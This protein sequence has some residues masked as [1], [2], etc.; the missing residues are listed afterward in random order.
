MRVIILLG[1][2]ICVLG[3]QGIAQ[4]T[5][6]GF[7][8]GNILDENK[9]AIEQATVRLISKTDSNRVYGAVTDKNGFFSFSAI[10]FDLYQLNIS[11]ISFK[12]LVIDS[13]HFR[14]ERF[15][16]NLQD[17]ILKINN[18][19]SLNE[20]VVYF[21]KPLI[22]SKEGNI[23][24]NAAESALAAGSTAS[25]LLQTVPLI[26]KDPNG[27]ILVRG[28]EPK[29][30]IDDK[31]VELN[32]QQLQDLLESLPGSSI[33]KIEVMTNPAPQYASEQGGVINIVTKK[34]KIGMGGRVSVSM[35]TRGEQSASGNFNYRKNKFA[36]NL[37]SGI[38][39][40]RFEGF[41]NSSRR[42]L[43]NDSSTYFNT[44]SNNHNESERPN[45]RIN[46]DYDLAKNQSLNFVM[47]FN[48][49]NFDNYNFITYTHLNTNYGTFGLSERT[50]NGIG[51][52][53]N[54][55]LNLTYTLRGKK[56]GG[57]LK[58]VAGSNNSNHVN[59]RL[60]NQQ[61]KLPN[62]LD[63]SQRQITDNKSSG[64]NF[65]INYDK[66]LSNKKTSIS[67]GNFYNF[68]KNDIVVDATYKQ[69]PGNV[70]IPHPFLSN[71]FQFQ[72]LQINLR[73]SV[74]QIIDEHFSF[75]LGVNTE[76]TNLRFDLLKEVKIV[77]NKYLNFLPF[78]NFN[79]NWDDK[80]NMTFSYRRTIR[81]PG[82]NEL[83]PS[84]DYSDSYNIRFGNYQLKPTLA[85][86]FDFVL[87]KTKASSFFN[88]GVGY[89]QVKN[90]FSTIRSLRSDG[91]TQITWE[92]IS[93]RKEYEI[94]SWN[95]FTIT[96]G[97]KVN[98]S[99]SYTYNAYSE[100]DKLKKKF[101][102]GASFSS[103]LNA[104]YLM[105]DNWNV[106]GNFTI[107]RFANPQGSVNWNLSMNMGIQKKFFKKKLVA[108]INFIDPFRNQQTKS[109]T[110][111]QNFELN[112]YQSSQTKNYR[113][114]LAYNFIKSPQKKIIQKLK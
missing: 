14:K 29:I 7:L 72:Q 60:F 81:R 45:F 63:S 30:L 52:N 94:S 10:E 20:V 42:Y 44:K 28:K 74:K 97:L 36:F 53:A 89:N 101:K 54:N 17:L 86:N 79:K 15:D 71:H 50:I 113:L 96:Q 5:N 93:S 80:L 43:F 58:I 16:F 59:N 35:G 49:N 108:T 114:T 18:N 65:R 61:F 39:F 24:F 68:I 69:Q 13:I 82:I 105:N 55:N 75:L 95:G 40:N 23:T 109:F 104:N 1:L 32:L 21:E 73:A 85:D 78:A 4:K 77:K 112:S 3:F 2:I 99:A 57:Q 27:K 102:N 84:I 67:V 87:G 100:F 51:N 62:I 41:G 37:N 8:L 91:S 76:A 9:K 56:K 90:I 110:Y 103:N 25:E 38:G 26:T 6:Q 92:N 33:E 70:F 12:N 107:N 31:P 111:G 106:T 22:Q 66:A 83:N 47:N 46:M 19:Q 34:G 11:H 88:I 48:Q 64:Y 98:L